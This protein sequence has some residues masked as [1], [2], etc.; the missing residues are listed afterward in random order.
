M[1]RQYN[2]NRRAR[3]DGGRLALS[4]SALLMVLCYPQVFG[5]AR[6]ILKVFFASASSDAGYLVIPIFLLC[7]MIGFF[8]LAVLLQF[9]P[10]LIL[11]SLFTR[12]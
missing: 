11:L 3:G 2:D 12:K 1:K 9:I 8:G 7:M 6:W 5:G 4:L 10:K